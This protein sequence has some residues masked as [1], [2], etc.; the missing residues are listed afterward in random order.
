MISVQNHQQLLSGN[1]HLL[2]LLFVALI[3]TASCSPKTTV[4]ASKP[5]GKPGTSLPPEKP[6]EKN[7]HSIALLLPFQLNNI[8]LQ[9]AGKKEIS[10]ADLAVDFYQGFKLA[11]DSL[12]AEE[13]EH[14]KLQVF[15]TQ[16]QETRMVNLAR[17][18][19]VR[20][21]DLIVGPIFPDGIQT[22]GDFAD[23]KF[24]LQVSPLAA[25][26]PA[27]FKNPNLVTVT[28]SID[29]HA[30]KI[31]D[32]IKNNYKPAQ[33]NII[34]INFK[35]PEDEKFGAPLRKY[36][37]ALAA[38]KFTFT[39]LANATT[40]ESSLSPAKTNLVILTSYA[41]DFVI[42]AIDK[43]YK[44]NQL[45]VRIQLFGHP[46]W[47]KA[48][49]LNAEKMQKLNTHITSSYFV[50]YKDEHTKNF[51][52]RYRDSYGFEPSEFAFK[53]FDCGYFFGGLL[54]NYGT[55]YADHL[56][57][58]TYSGLHNNFRFERDDTSGYRNSN[59][60]MLEYRD[61]ELQLTE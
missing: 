37:Q 51:I 20:D 21:N 55:D 52:A 13:G 29:Q 54:G 42:P 49:F 40:L 4:P 23:L 9:T 8:N 10:Q 25:V 36:L 16:D 6:R 38:G 46:N 43:L 48:Q 57:N 31:A 32:F 30:S 56:K 34:L 59:V 11:L 7:V 18:S 19:S 12:A 41:K 53:G 27:Q 14:F 15:D 17:A 5:S 33:V 28:S 22:F 1:K 60:I 61:F 3:L 47:A 35:K 24:K 45:N 50:N 44:S 2:S 58:K 26:A 39:E